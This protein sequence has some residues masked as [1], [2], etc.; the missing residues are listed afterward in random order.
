MGTTNNEKEPKHFYSAFKTTFF[1][2]VFFIVPFLLGNYFLWLFQANINSQILE[3]RKKEMKEVLSHAVRRTDPVNYYNDLAVKIAESFKEKSLH[4]ILSEECK[5]NENLYLFNADGKRIIWKGA[6]RSK[7]AISERFA[8]I[9]LQHLNNKQIN[10]GDFTNT[11]QAVLRNFLGSS[12]AA[13]GLL[14]NLNSMQDFSILGLPKFGGLYESSTNDLEAPQAYSKIYL[15]VWMDTNNIPHKELATK[16]L[17]FAADKSAMRDYKFAWVDP[18][19]LT[20]SHVTDDLRLKKSATA[21]LLEEN[22]RSFRIYDKTLIHRQDNDAGLRL[23][24]FSELPSRTD[25]LQRYYDLLILFLPAILALYILA[26]SA[27][28]RIS[29]SVKY[30]ALAIML[31]V[32]L[33]GFATLYAGALFYLEQRKESIVY[34]YKTTANEILGQTDRSFELFQ[35]ALVRQYDNA[36]RNLSGKG[37]EA[38]EI[39]A[40]L[41][42][43]VKHGNA[44]IIEILDING[45]PIRKFSKPE[46]EIVEY[47]F[48]IILQG[49]VR[50]L[51]PRYNSSREGQSSYGQYEA[52]LAN[53][54]S[55]PAEELLLNRGTLFYL[56]IQD[57]ASA[58]Y[59]DF[60]TDKNN[61]AHSAL[62][63]VH[64]SIGLELAHIKERA[65][66]L[67]TDS[68]YD[69]YA[70]P[71]METLP[72]F[73]FPSHEA[74]S[75]EDIRQL[76][77]I[78]K[79]QNAPAFTIG[80][81]DNK[82][83]F[84]A[85]V[86]ANNLKNYN[87]FLAMPMKEIDKKIG[88]YPLTFII[89][90][91]FFFTVVAIVSY[92][93]TL[94][95]LEPTEQTNS[96]IKA[97]NRGE[98]SIEEP[99]TKNYSKEDLDILS[100]SS[101]IVKKIKEFD[102]G[103]SIEY[104]LI[105][106][107][108]AIRQDFLLDGRRLGVS[109]EENEIYYFSEEIDDTVAVF[110]MKTEEQNLRALITLSTA[111]MAVKLIIEE[112]H[113]TDPNVIIRQLE[114]YFRI[115]LR[116][117]LQGDAMC[118]TTNFESKK[119]SA[120]LYGNATLMLA[121]ADKEPSI[122]KFTELRPE[123]KIKTATPFVLDKDEALLIV[124]K[125]APAK[126]LN[127]INKDYC[128]FMRDAVR[129]NTSLAAEIYENANKT[130]INYYGEIA[131]IIS[132][133][134]LAKAEDTEETK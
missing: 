4:E 2:A 3:D 99:D 121:G 55:T 60:I 126:L 29:F 8:K 107:K 111:R 92:F 17:E 65:A 12:P 43:T 77:Y 1:F 50:T 32:L 58:L 119:I 100:G 88:L 41:E 132:V 52:L 76:N 75:G 64:S 23:A 96:Y 118:I 38:S 84:L 134:R 102:L 67:Q 79:E 56:I 81:I 89:F 78:V 71:K 33:A 6:N 125:T 35:N 114:E 14:R 127:I 106:K 87:I 133:Q 53:V 57:Y 30:Q 5:A 49:I 116:E 104:N 68:A 129:K 16:A 45:T 42:N 101:Q 25:I 59:F 66:F 74:V 13:I 36:I 51:F 110:F 70:I 47:S 26:I 95:L 93:A 122:I 11:E 61:V 37:L 10:R 31:Y 24:V 72:R 22:L 94:K 7:I 44:E 117:P 18:N 27:P 9:L 112:L 105:P 73:S 34:N 97:L 40:E 19:D 69:F 80:T 103:D 109:L 28:G 123:S 98:L 128:T 62:I 113:V 21:M 86:S 124:S 131:S 39:T 115:N 46:S 48:M 120:S 82:K 108:Y 130:S 63:A 83:V 20:S 90:S 91:S 15:L 85:G 54:L